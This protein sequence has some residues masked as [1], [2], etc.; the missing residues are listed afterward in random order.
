MAVGKGAGWFRGVGVVEGVE[1]GG[2][3]AASWSRS[4]TG[5]WSQSAPRRLVAHS[6]PIRGAGFPR[7][8]ARRLRCV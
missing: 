5:A 2:R 3:E 8:A 4:Q 7:Q 6:A 1:G